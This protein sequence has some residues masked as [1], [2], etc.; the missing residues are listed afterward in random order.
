MISVLRVLRPYLGRHRRPL[1]LAGLAMIGEVLASLASPWPLKFIFDSVLFE[2]TR[3]GQRGLR[4]SL[5]GHTLVLLVAL[6][7]ASVV[8]ALLNGICSYVDDRNTDVVGQEAIY[9]LRRALFSHLQRLTISF[10]HGQDTRVGDL[11]SRL[12]T[13]IQSL[14]NLAAAGVSNLVTNGLSIVIM[15]AIMYWLDWRLATLVLVMTIPVYVVA[16]RTIVDMKAALKQARKQE[17]SV[18]AVLQEALSSVR[19]IQAFGREDYESR[20]LDQES[21][22]SLA[23]N[24][25]AAKLQSRLIPSMSVLSAISVAAVTG[26]G[27]SLAVSRSITPGDLLVFISYLAGLQSP[28]RQLL[29]LSYAIGRASAG[30]ERIRETFTHEPLHE[31]PGAPEIGPVAGRVLFED[32]TFGYDENI[33]VIRG[34]TLDAHPGQVIAIVGPTGAGKSTIVSL[35]PRFYDPWKGRVLIDGTDIRDVSLSSLRSQIALVLQDSLIFRA[36]IRENIAFGRPDATNEEIEEA[37]EAAGVTAM[38]RQFED[39]FDTMVSERGTSLSG[40]QKQCIALARAILK[41]A[42]IVVLDEPTS[43][44]DSLTEHFVMDGFARLAAG[45]TTF[46]IAHRLAT[47]RNADVVAVLDNGEIV[48]LGQ[49]TNLLSRTTTRFAQYARTQALVLGREEGQLSG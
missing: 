17:G 12:S 20:R 13:D 27:V 41:N 43:S 22:K 19:L 15:V 30:V 3:G 33:P 5:S 28:I 18:S 1:I 45:R 2:H 38:V 14:Q 6:L 47:V 10:H 39:G 26:Y 34:V 36:T 16:R 44:M 8:I 21:R 11:L 31:V 23:A 9:D 25:N 4:T 49:P 48:E 32:V 24:L 7:A 42:P 46:V 29:K 35:L 37:A 40:G